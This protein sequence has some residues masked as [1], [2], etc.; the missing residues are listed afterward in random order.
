M[1]VDWQGLIS[2]SV[3]DF[4]NERRRHRRVDANVQTEI[5]TRPE[6]AASHVVAKDISL[7]GCY[8]ETMFTLEPG[9]KASLTFW[10]GE[11][12]DQSHSTG[13]NETS[14][15]WEWIRIH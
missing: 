12:Q 14:P 8:V 5:R 11:K 13:C 3:N 4:A 7:C 10:F 1:T 6:R 9:T 2:T 15:S